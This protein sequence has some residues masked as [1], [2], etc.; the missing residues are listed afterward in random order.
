MYAI[1]TYGFPP[2]IED[3]KKMKKILEILGFQVVLTV[4][5]E[6]ELYE[7]DFEN[8]HIEA[9]IDYLP[10]LEQYFIE[11]EY[12]SDYSSCNNCILLVLFVYK[13]D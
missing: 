6:R 4:K 1:G 9:L 2:K 11:V 5:K 7:F 12:L 8:Y 10:I 3:I 13:V